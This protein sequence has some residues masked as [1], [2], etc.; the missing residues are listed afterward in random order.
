MASPIACA[1]CVGCIRH[2]F[3]SLNRGILSSF[4]QAFLA[5][6]RSK[7]RRKVVVSFSMSYEVDVFLNALFP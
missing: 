6:S 3:H 4:Q 1:R 5:S 2:G 7:T